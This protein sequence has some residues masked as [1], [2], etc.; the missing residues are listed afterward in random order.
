MGRVISA[1]KYGKDK[2][3]GSADKARVKERDMKVDMPRVGTSWKT[4]FQLL[5]KCPLEP[6][7]V[8][9]AVKSRELEGMAYQIEG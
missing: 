6:G 7:E 2:C 8:V 9:P 5:G 1:R 3:L 4:K